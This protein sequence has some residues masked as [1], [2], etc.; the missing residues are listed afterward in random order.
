MSN[1]RRE[2]FQSSLGVNLKVRALWR[3]DETETHPNPDNWYQGT[4]TE[5]YKHKGAEMC[6]VRYYDGTEQCHQLP[7]ANQNHANNPIVSIV[8]DMVPSHHDLL[9]LTK[10][11]DPRNPEI[12]VCAKCSDFDDECFYRAKIITLKLNQ[13][14]SPIRI[15]FTDDEQECQVYRKNI[16]V[17]SGVL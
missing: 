4:I 6:V 8:R 16:R 14:D 3:N 9:T 15:K 5:L 7:I 17:L 10:N 11:L 13:P 1:Q 2:V 12:L